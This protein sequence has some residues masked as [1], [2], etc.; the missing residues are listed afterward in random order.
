M[1][2]VRLKLLDKN[3]GE[4][5]CDLKLG[6]GTWAIQENTDNSNF[7]KIKNILFA[8]NIVKIMKR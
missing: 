6:K 1:C 5:L 8:Q 7:C 4:N 3:I 2:N